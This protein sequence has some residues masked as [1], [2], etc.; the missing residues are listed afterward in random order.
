[1]WT[2][3]GVRKAGIGMGSFPVTGR[4]ESSATSTWVVPRS[5]VQI[6]DKVK[7]FFFLYA[8]NRHKM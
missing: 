8:I 3:L 6:A 1:V 7:R 5:C 2:V 4:G